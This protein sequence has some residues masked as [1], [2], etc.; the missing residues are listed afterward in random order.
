M[1]IDGLNAT[2]SR[3]SGLMKLI[4]QFP[5]VIDRCRALAAEPATRLVNFPPDRSHDCPEVDAMSFAVN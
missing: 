3:W 1:L 4:D 5:T 2:E